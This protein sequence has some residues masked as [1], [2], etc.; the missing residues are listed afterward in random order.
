[1]LSV[2]EPVPEP[3]PRVSKDHRGAKCFWPFGDPREP[4]FHFCGAVAIE[5]KPYCADHCALAYKVRPARGE[6]RAA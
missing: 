4:E 2:I 6:E 5:G 3:L 1:M